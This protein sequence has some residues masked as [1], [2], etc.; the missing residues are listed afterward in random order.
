[1]D[2]FYAWRFGAV[3]A[4]CRYLITLLPV[5]PE[6]GFPI[7][8]F[9]INVIGSFVIGLVA[10]LAAKNAMNPKAVLFLKVGICGGFT[11]FSSFALETE[12]E[13]RDRHA[14]CHSESC[15]RSPGCLRG[16]TADR[17][18][19]G[20]SKNIKSQSAG[21]AVNADRQRRSKVSGRKPVMHYVCHQSQTACPLPPDFTCNQVW[22]SG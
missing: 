22:F 2:M 14:V 6:N 12:G 19:L 13:H 10:A 1:M 16:R 9:M 21:R 8:T 7:K 15:L 20:E 4:I 17:V 5:H 3:G 11:T 18:R